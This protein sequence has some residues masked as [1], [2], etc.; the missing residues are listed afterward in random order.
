MQRLNMTTGTKMNLKIYNLMT[1]EKLKQVSKTNENAKLL[2]AAINDWPVECD[3]V[4]KFI[5]S[6]KKTYNLNDDNLNY[7]DLFEKNSKI[8][9]L[10][11]AWESESVSSLLIILKNGGNLIDIIW[12]LK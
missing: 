5:R 10:E 3:T 6:L 9:V 7:S 1:I 4:E 11:H 12:N 8:N 2:I